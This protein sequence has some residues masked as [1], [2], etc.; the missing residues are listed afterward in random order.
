[1]NRQ[2]RLRQFTPVLAIVLLAV[3]S[4]FAK[5]SRI[6]KVA[7]PASLGGTAVV[8]GEYKL[9]LKSH[10]ADADVTVVKDKKVVGTTHGQWVDRGTEYDQN[11]MVFDTAADGSRSIIEIRFAGSKRVLVFG[12]ETSVAGSGSTSAPTTQSAPSAKPGSPG[13]SQ[14]RFL[15]KPSRTP[16]LLL[17]PQLV[18]SPHVPQF[19]QPVL[20]DGG[21]AAQPGRRPNN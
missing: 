3:T 6:V 13:T 1:M 12:G 15:G 20:I 19:K 5:D 21:A 9:Q 7:Y 8:P 11:A 14:F 4:G 18:D 2:G 16:Q 17:Q 10:H